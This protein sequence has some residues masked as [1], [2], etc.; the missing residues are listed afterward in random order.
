MQFV[1][2]HGD[3]HEPPKVYAI[4]GSTLIEEE[5]YYLGSLTYAAEFFVTN[6]GEHLCQYGAKF[7]Y[8]AQHKVLVS[9]HSHPD[10]YFSLGCQLKMDYFV[11]RKYPIDGM[12]TFIEECVRML[13]SSGSTSASTPVSVS[14]PAPISA[15][16]AAVETVIRAPAAAAAAAASWTEPKR[17]RTEEGGDDVLLPEMPTE[18]AED[19]KFSM[20]EE[21][22]TTNDIVKEL[23][24]AFKQSGWFNQRLTKKA[25]YVTS[26]SN[27]K[28]AYEKQIPELVEQMFD[29]FMRTQIEMIEGEDT[30]EKKIGWFELAKKTQAFKTFKMKTVDK[31]IEDERRDLTKRFTDLIVPAKYRL[32]YEYDVDRNQLIVYDAVEPYVQ[33]IGSEAEKR[34]VTF[35]P[36]RS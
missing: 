17:T 34:G 30:P 2:V 27:F 22:R 35:H 3:A 24:F 29:D 31:K 19:Q 5:P 25:S 4:N 7:K 20:F 36:Y 18:Y 32:R 28:N 13:L 6:G 21:A 10:F 12:L 8:D 9:V 23:P 26:Y 33:W 14:V 1:I 11:V 15:A 16:A